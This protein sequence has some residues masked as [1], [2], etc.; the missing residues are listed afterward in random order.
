MS[1]FFRVL[2]KRLLLSAAVKKILVRFVSTRT[3][4]SDSCGISSLGGVGDGAGCSES[5]TRLLR[6]FSWTSVLCVCAH[7]FNGTAA[8]ATSNVTRPVIKT[9]FLIALLDIT[10]LRLNAISLGRVSTFG[11]HLEVFST[12]RESDVDLPETAVVTV[13]DRFVGNEI[14]GAQL[15]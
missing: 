5:V 15:F 2:M 1:S 11:S 12:L 10:L 14:L 9:R 4:S 8:T 6:D 3:T 13:I 7:I